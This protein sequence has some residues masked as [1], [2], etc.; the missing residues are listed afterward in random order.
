MAFSPRYTITP[1]ILKAISSIEVSR[2]E[3]LGLPITASLLVSLRES[4]RITSTHHSTAIEGNRLSPSEV[5][6][7]IQGGGHFPNRKKDESEVRNYYK[8]LELMETLARKT[9]SITEKDIKTLHGL[10]FEGWLKPTPYREGQNVIRSGKLVVYI[11]PKAEDVPTLMADLI[12]WIEQTVKQDLPIPFI[13]GLAHYQ[14]AT[15]HPYYDGNGRTARLLATLILHKYGYDLKGIY[16]LEEYYAHNLQAYYNALTVGSDEDYYEGH[17]ATADLTGFLE[18]FIEGMAESFDKVRQSAEKA[19]KSGDMDQSLILR[20]LSPKQ[21]Q[22][23]KLFI[24]SQKI[25]T[26]DMAQFFQL[27]D[28]QARHLCQKWV[29]EGFLE[30]SNPAPKTRDFRLVEKYEALVR[31]HLSQIKGG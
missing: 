15:I 11:P 1:K 16:S 31:D 28:R 8:A 18:Y 13:A 30:I 4:A 10:S 23:L 20:H 5:A 29:N 12:K 25:T 26:K 19:Q 9:Q 24:S 22:A 21:R 3:I 17:R 6:E 2:H 7:I 27:S 14:F